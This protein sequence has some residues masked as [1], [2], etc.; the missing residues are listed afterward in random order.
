MGLVAGTVRCLG[1]ERAHKKSFAKIFG[2]CWV[3]KRLEWCAEAPEGKRGDK[4]PRLQGQTVNG[5]G[6]N[7]NH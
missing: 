4:K 7:C 2:A 1:G 5:E 6:S 3:E